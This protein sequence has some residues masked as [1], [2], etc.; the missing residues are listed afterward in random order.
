M[1]ALPNANAVL[2]EIWTLECETRRLEVGGYGVSTDTVI[3]DV[4][5]SV[6]FL[7]I[8]GNGTYWTCLSDP[9][10]TTVVIWVNFFKLN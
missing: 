2:S 5:P 4:S 9:T 10:H 8:K 1:R 3:T 6:P 7:G